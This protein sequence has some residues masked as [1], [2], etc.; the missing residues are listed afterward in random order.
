MLFQLFFRHG[1]VGFVVDDDEIL[2]VF[3][4]T[5]HNALEENIFSFFTFRVE[6]TGWE[7]DGKRHFFADVGGGFHLFCQRSS[8]EGKEGGQ[9]A[10]FSLLREKDFSFFFGE[11][12]LFH[13]LMQGGLQGFCIGWK[14]G[15]VYHFH[16]LMH[17]GAERG[18]LVFRFIA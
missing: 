17:E 10:G 9:G 13:Q 4:K 6:G 15:E 12:L 8:G 5:V 2:F 7:K 1:A 18:P 14:G 3:Q 11:N 16:G